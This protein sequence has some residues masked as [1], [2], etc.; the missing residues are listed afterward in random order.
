[1]P[2]ADARVRQGCAAPL[3]GFTVVP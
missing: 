3:S 2:L 1:M